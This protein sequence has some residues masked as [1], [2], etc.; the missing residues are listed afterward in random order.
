[1]LKI[2]KMCLLLAG[3]GLTTACATGSGGSLLG[4]ERTPAEKRTLINEMRGDALAELYRK[5]PGTREELKNAKGYAVF[6]TVD[7]KVL[8]IGGGGGRGVVHD[9][10]NNKDTWMKMGT[11]SA[12]LGLGAKDMRIIMVFHD[13]NKLDDFL[14]GGWDFGG[15]ADASAAAGDVGGS[16]DASGSA[17]RGVNVYQFTENGLSLQANL[18]GTKFWRDNGLN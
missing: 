12:G 18:S 13:A 4:D 9:N 1:M 6:S 11:A 8:F 10:R 17:Q 2:V 5:R 7:V 3:M 16:R 14:D 15:D